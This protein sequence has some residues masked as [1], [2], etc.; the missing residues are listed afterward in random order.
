[1]E[2]YADQV[3][4]CIRAALHQPEL[5]L[6]RTGARLHA[7]MRAEPHKTSCRWW[8]VVLRLVKR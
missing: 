2:A 8:L 5:S 6:S 1:M 4:Y 7:R 3:A